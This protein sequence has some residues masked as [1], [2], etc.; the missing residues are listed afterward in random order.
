MSG[1][2][3]MRDLF[4]DLLGIDGVKGVLFFGLSGQRLFE[5]FTIREND[6]GRGSDWFALAVCLGKAH[7]AEL[8]FERGRIYIRR[9]AGGVLVV[10]MDLNAPSEM[11]RLTCDILISAIREPKPV[12]GIKRFFKL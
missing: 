8:V 5:E 7:E 10:V 3:A 1:V 6:P 4:K 11:I 9:S 12:R 2:G